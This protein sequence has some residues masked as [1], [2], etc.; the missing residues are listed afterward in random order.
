MRS[1]QSWPVLLK[2]GQMVNGSGGSGCQ[3][4]PE[5][6]QISDPSVTLPLSL[7]W[8]ENIFGIRQGCHQWKGGNSKRP[9]AVVPHQ[10]SDP[11][12]TLPLSAATSSSNFWITGITSQYSIH[13]QIFLP[14]QLQCYTSCEQISDVKFFDISAS[15]L[16]VPISEQADIKE[17]Q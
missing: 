3:T 11:S 16:E 10:I 7:L 15:K 2:G 8:E 1:E 6:Q 14:R 12:V 17:N 5:S 9:V 4:C 13:Q